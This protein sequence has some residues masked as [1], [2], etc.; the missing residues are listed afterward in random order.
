M[1]LRQLL[2]LRQLRPQIH[3]LALVGAL[4]LGRAGRWQQQG[5]KE[6]QAALG[7]QKQGHLQ[8]PTLR[9]AETHCD[10]P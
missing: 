1:Y 9:C 8:V 10:S 3:A 5:L 6:A 4:V 7:L 2:V